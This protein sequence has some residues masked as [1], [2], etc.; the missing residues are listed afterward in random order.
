MTDLPMPALPTSEPAPNY[1]RRWL[2]LWAYVTRPV[3][4][5]LRHRGRKPTP[6]EL[7]IRQREAEELAKQ[8]ATEK[9]LDQLAADYKRLIIN[10][11]TR[12]GV[13]HKSKED[14]K[15]RVS[16]VQFH[17]PALVTTEAIYY[18][19][20]TTH[21]PWHIT[22]DD[23]MEESTVNT[24]MAATGR[25]IQVHWD[26]QAPEKGFWI[27]VELKAGVRGIPKRV[28]FS[29][30]LKEIPKTASRMAVMLGRGVAGKPVFD[31]FDEMPH[32]LVAGATGG[33]KTVWIEQALL[34]LILRNTPKQ[35]KI[36]LVDLKNGVDLGQFKRIPHLIGGKVVRDV[37]GVVPVLASAMK[38]IQRRLKLFEEN[39]DVVNIDAWNQRNRRKLPRI[40]LVIDELAEVMLT[41]L[42]SDAEVLLARIG[43]LGRAAGVHALIATQR[44]ERAVITG[45]IKANFTTRL[46]FSC[47]DQ[48]SSKIIL[49]SVDAAGIGPIG[50]MIYLKGSRKVELQGPFVSPKMIQETVSQIA[51]GQTVEVLETR[52]RHNF[53]PPDFFQ[54]AIERYPGRFPIRPIYE[55]LKG[56]GVT[57]EELLE[58]ALHHEGTEF[59]I[60][61]DIYTLTGSVTSGVKESRQLIKVGTKLTDAED[62]AEPDA[63]IM[64]E[65][66]I[67]QFQAIQITTFSQMPTL[68]DADDD[69][70]D[71]VGSETDPA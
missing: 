8:R 56:Y 49:D 13:S 22:I 54:H 57:K 65:P 70:D 69:P 11:L 32:L 4:H 12:V 9:Q 17:K 38:E 30:M 46:A 10:A 52:K 3:R 28:D 68:P 39:G 31:S 19:V 67:E 41:D 34:T 25:V 43:A 33:G 55:D 58:I 71:G 36:S 59:E 35:L 26:K 21:L 63:D 2:R 37:D 27:I 29:A 18:Q 24:L 7:A 40:L 48:A 20:M 45:L 60:D 1:S 6:E 64:P 51:A 50:R 62:D 66:P 15:V 61:G 44:P 14:G 16:K 47:A 42:K 5:A 53:T 23:L